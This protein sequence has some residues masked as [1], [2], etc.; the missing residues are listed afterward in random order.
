MIVGEG[1]DR[2]ALVELA[3]DLGIGDVTQFVGA[4]P[5][6][7]VP[8]CLNNID[9]YAALSRLDSESFGVAIIEASAC[10]LPVVGERIGGRASQ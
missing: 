4:I 3:T 5:Y 1:A 8:E 6:A 9:I 2:Q 7:E 10:G